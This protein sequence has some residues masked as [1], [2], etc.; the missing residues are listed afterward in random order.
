MEQTGKTIKGRNLII[1]SVLYLL[2]GTIVRGGTGEAHRDIWL[3]MF[4]NLAI[5]TAVTLLY[6]YVCKRHP[7]RDLFSM[8]YTSFSKQSALALS[9]IYIAYGILI[10]SMSWGNFSNFTSL[11]ILPDS[12]TYLAL[13]FLALVCVYGAKKGIYAVTKYASFIFA[14]VILILAVTIGL[15][16]R[17]MD[18]FELLPIC[19]DFRSFWNETLT[20]TAFPFGDTILLFVAYE[21]LD[22]EEIRPTRFVSGV[23][24]AFFILSLIMVRNVAVLGAPVLSQLRY[25]TY[26]AMGVVGVE[27]FFKRI[28]I[29]LVFAVIFCDVIKGVIALLFVST[30][31]CR[32]FGLK[33]RETLI[34]PLAFLT[35]GLSLVAFESNQSADAVLGILRYFSLPIQIIGP[36]LVLLKS[37]EKHR[38]ERVVT[39]K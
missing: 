37:A 13:F 6:C 10:G 29:L 22:R 25:A 36:G 14:F 4:I 15:S 16:V 2:S 7:N 8:F 26:H 1:I 19:Y 5:F 30:G 3:S 34:I 31:I 33:K 23:W 24:I 21:A 39:K 38:R 11:N 20:L 9:L 17:H 32:V 27:D 35:A 28:E 12:P 18:F